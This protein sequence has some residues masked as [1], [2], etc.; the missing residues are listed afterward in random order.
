MRP[1]VPRSGIKVFAELTLQQAVG[2]AHLLLFAQ[3]HSVA[4]W[5]AWTT[6]PMLSRASIAA[7]KGA[8]R[9]ALVAFKKQFYPLTPA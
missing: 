2:A 6:R 7:L 4:R 5:F 9:H 1:G 3:L 8:F